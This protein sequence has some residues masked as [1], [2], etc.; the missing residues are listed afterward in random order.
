MP[1]MALEVDI[2]EIYPPIPEKT[3]DWGL[4]DWALNGLIHSRGT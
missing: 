3:T 2:A 4:S 1:V